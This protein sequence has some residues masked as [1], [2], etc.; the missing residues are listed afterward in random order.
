V[1]ELRAQMEER[2]ERRRCPD[3]LE[4]QH[5]QPACPQMS[6]P[7][8]L[9]RDDPGPPPAH[10]MTMQDELAKIFADVKTVMV[11]D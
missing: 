5:H 3:C 8:G 1:D 7:S 11:E 6:F 4:D 10:S 2:T 9:R